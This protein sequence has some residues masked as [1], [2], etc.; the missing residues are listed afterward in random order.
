MKEIQYYQQGDVLLFLEKIP[1]SAVKQILDPVIMHGE[2][3]HK[4]KMNDEFY[5]DESNQ[6]PF[7]KFEVI[8]DPNSNV[9]YLRVFSPSDLT[10]EEHKR[11]TLPPGEYRIGQVREKGMFDDMINPVLD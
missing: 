1:K 7:K 9:I 8:K 5:S 10:H 6:K 11:I 3:G 2:S 4:H